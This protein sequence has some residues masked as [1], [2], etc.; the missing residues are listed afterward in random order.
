MLRDFSYLQNP[1]S[2]AEFCV[3][4][5]GPAGMTVALEL[6]RAGR[7]VILL[8]AGDDG[9]SAQSQDIYK[10]AVIGDPYFDLDVARLRQLGGSSN[11]WRGMC[12]VLDEVDF[13]PKE[14]FSRARWPISK[15][16]LN[17]Y[18]ARASEIFEVQIPTE[19]ILIDE[20][21]GIKEIFFPVSPVNF[22]DKYRG[23]LDSSQNL[24]YVLD[25]NVT[26]I[27][28]DG[29]RT[30]ALTVQSFDGQSATISS[31]TYIL[32][33]G[34]I[35]NSRLLLWSNALANGALV[36]RHVP[37]GRYWMEHPHYTVGS[38]IVDD[39]YIEY[40][41]FAMTRERQTAEKVLNC[42]LRLIP[43]S[44]EGTKKLIADLACVAPVTAEWFSDQIGL[45][46]ACVA[47]LWA[48]SEQEPRPDNRVALSRDEK[49]MFGIPLT[50][51]HWRKSQRDQETLRQTALAFGEHL[52]DSGKG[53]LRLDSWLLESGDYP[54]DAPIGGNHHMGGTRMADN[55]YDGVV[56]PNCRVYGQE[57]LF[58]AGSSV[59]PS[60]GCSNPTVTIVQ[61]ALRLADH[62]KR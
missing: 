27:H 14:E 36:P 47:R 35:E 20:S 10:G 41:Y 57:N 37:L 52:V 2:K 17:P 39:D 51:L 31:D 19:D 13:E 12:R 49:D 23:E 50:E 44:Y 29:R 30:T 7:S 48:V 16:D 60:G 8:E 6:S 61:L 5:S 4:G 59:F 24:N 40:T 53:R 28:T 9:W 55:P 11:H 21:N 33:T 34:G 32:A 38:A 3:I 46:L 43:T 42:S 18:T 1:D 54:V 45:N 58:I 62:L 25:A 22:A 56:D 15:A 26:Q